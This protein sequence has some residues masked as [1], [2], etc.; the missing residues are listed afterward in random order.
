MDNEKAADYL[1]VEIGQN[2]RTIQWAAVRLDN[3]INEGK[4]SEYEGYASPT[5]SAIFDAGKTSRITVAHLMASFIT[6]D[7]I[8]N[9]W[10][11][12]MPVIYNKGV[13][14]CKTMRDRQH[15]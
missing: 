3:L 8:R 15:A 10:K 12:Q 1:R 6:D 5:R 7:D 4:V 13:R 14:E 11:G 9:K 2:D